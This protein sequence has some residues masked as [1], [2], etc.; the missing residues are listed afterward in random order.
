MTRGGGKGKA[1]KADV[2]VVGDIRTLLADDD[3]VGDGCH[4]VGG[5][6]IPVRRFREWL[7]AGDAF[8]K[9]VV[10]DGVDV[11]HVQHF[12]RHIPAHL[13]TALELGEPPLFDGLVCSDPSCGR[14]YKLELDHLVPF[15][16][17]GA[18]SY[19]NL[20]GKCRG[21]HQTKTEADRAAGLLTPPNPN[22]RGGNSP[23]DG[24]GPAG[25]DE[26][27]PP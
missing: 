1:G 27:G 11:L 24:G 7:E 23:A 18:T 26:R 5:G 17:G 19:R 4:I 3:S 21:E 15:A 8:I 9:G 16:A 25:G 10:H 22:D 13:R 6:P 2:V 12:G 20:D 14:R